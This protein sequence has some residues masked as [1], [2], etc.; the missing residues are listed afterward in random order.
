MSLL[1]GKK[2]LIT[3]GGT[4]E[5]WDTVRGHTNLAKGTMGCYLAEEALNHEAEVIYLHG[6][7]AK[8]PENH[9]NMRLIQF[10]GIDDLGGKIK[11]LVQSE[12]IDI[13][14]MAAAGS[15]WVVDK[16]VDQQGNPILETGK[17]TSDE[18]PIIHFKKAPKVLSQIKRWNPNILLVG[19][20]LEHTVDHKYLF[21]RAKLRMETSKAEFMVA[22]KTGS[23][24]GEE[25]EHFIVSTFQSPIKYSSKKETAEGLIHCLAGQIN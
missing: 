10:E 8:L 24:Y 3:S 11:K 19:F 23:L 14:I 15:D 5:K 4:L 12:H 22:N 20:K 1:K 6:Y 7:F 21:E 9:R 16:V 18:P 25:S 17:M 2:I 13:V